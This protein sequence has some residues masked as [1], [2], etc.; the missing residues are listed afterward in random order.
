MERYRLF[1]HQDFESFPFSLKQEIHRLEKDLK[2]IFS[3]SHNMK[4]SAIHNEREYLLN[5]NRILK[6]ALSHKQITKDMISAFPNS[7]LIGEIKISETAIG[8]VLELK[9]IS[10]LKTTKRLFLKK[11]IGEISKYISAI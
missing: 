6:I 4:F 5:L 3:I 7:V 2:N 8:L 9:D 11:K 10:S 1:S